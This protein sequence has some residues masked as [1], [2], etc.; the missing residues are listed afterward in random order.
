MILCEG[1]LLIKY[2]VPVNQNLHMMVI[3]ENCI[4]IYR[5]LLLAERKFQGFGTL[6]FD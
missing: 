1:I 2:F 5:A 3:H 6:G 4:S